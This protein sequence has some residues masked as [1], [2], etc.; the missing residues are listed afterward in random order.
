MLVD[1]KT[2]IKIA[3]IAAATLIG[4]LVAWGGSYQGQKLGGFSFFALAVIASYLVQWLIFIPAALKGTEKFY[5]LA[6]GIG[7]VG[8]TLFLLLATPQ[9][10]PL[11]WVLGFMVMIWSARLSLFLFSRVLGAKGDDRFDEIKKDRLRFFLTW[12]LQAL[13]V[14]VTA[15]AAWAAITSGRAATITWLS[16]VGIALWAIGFTLEIIA[17]QQKS[18]FKADP[19]NAGKFMRSGIW[20]RSRHPNYFGEIL[21]WVGVLVAAVPALVGWQWVVLISPLLV[22]VLLTRVSGIPLLEKKADQRWGGQADYEEYKANT[23]VLI[24]RLGK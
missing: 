2:L 13:W 5:D 21:L 4:A 18:A 16:I 20:S 15:S 17:D 11:G 24:P 19:A 12:T 9:V 22:I 8:I 14:A 23:P 7:F 3:V 6:G 10:S 1:K